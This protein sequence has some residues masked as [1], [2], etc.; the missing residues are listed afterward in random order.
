MIA[1]LLWA[2]PGC[3]FFFLLFDTIDIKQM[4]YVNFAVDLIRTS[5]LCCWD[6]LLYQLSHNHC[7]LFLTCG[8]QLKDWHSV[9]STGLGL[10]PFYWTLIVLKLHYFKW[11][12]RNCLK[13]RESDDQQ[14]DW[15]APKPEQLQR[16]YVLGGH[17]FQEGLGVYLHARWDIFKGSGFYVEVSTSK[18]LCRRWLWHSWGTWFKYL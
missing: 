17:A 10:A 4:F 9:C 16:V 15:C 3:F 18:F 7:Q 13:G 5:V 11:N 2:I 14:S 1:F 8:C 12:L 6:R